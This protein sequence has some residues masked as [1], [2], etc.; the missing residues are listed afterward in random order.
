MGL[1]EVD[2]FAADDVHVNAIEVPEVWW[3]TQEE[4]LKEGLVEGKNVS[5]ADAICV[6][7]VGTD[8]P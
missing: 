2:V 1:R 5:H 4:P 7:F 6:Y 8:L 3:R